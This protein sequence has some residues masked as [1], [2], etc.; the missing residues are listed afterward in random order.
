MSK[1]MS[2]K[3]NELY[4][5]ILVPGGFLS[6]EGLQLLMLLQHCLIQ[7]QRLLLLCCHL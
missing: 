6:Q 1:Q 7:L 4:L 2:D 5:S 3:M